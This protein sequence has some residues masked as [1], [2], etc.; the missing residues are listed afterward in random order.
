MSIRM[1]LDVSAVQCKRCQFFPVNDLRLKVFFDTVEDSFVDLAAKTLID[2]VPV[3]EVPGKGSPL[4]T[5]FGDVLRGAE[6]CD[7]RDGYIA[8][9]F[10]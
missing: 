9:L 1:N 3:P 8:T 4:A 10:R 5:V 2:G 6:K 7:I